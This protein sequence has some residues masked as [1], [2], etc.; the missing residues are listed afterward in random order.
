MKTSQNILYTVVRFDLCIM[1][2]LLFFLGMCI[3]VKSDNWFQ[4]IMPRYV[5]RFAFG[6]LQI[7]IS[8]ADIGHYPG[9][10]KDL[11]TPQFKQMRASAAQ[12]F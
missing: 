3:F 4:F 11:L 9:H 2:L 5:K 6:E 10:L 7:H 12:M 8:I 1:L